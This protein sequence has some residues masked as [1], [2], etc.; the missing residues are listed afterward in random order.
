MNKTL[1][2][3]PL[4]STNVR[5]KETLTTV[6]K[7]LIDLAYQKKP[8]LSA[9]FVT[10]YFFR[11][12]MMRE[13]PHFKKWSDKADTYF[14]PVENTE[15]F[16][17]SYSWGEGPVVILM[18]GWAGRGLQL[19]SFIEPLVA[20]G[21]KVVT[22]DAPAHGDSTG[23]TTNFFEFYLS[24]KSVINYH[25]NVE[26]IIAHS[27]GCAAALANADFFSFIPKLALIAPQYDI[28][29]E[30]N[31]WSEK[32]LLSKKNF[33]KTH[34]FLEDKY[35]LD[36]ENLNPKKMASDLDAEVLLVHD[37]DDLPCP[38][39]NSVQLAKKLKQ[40]QLHLTEGLGHYRIVR[41]PKVIAKVIDFIDPKILN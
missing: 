34:R 4:K 26:S 21:Y 32:T 1:L 41:S 33:N 28:N 31:S 3:Q 37:R 39:S 12:Q 10:N 6:S 22:F 36:L 11:P 17:K 13:K 7:R 8:H 25:Q 27:M 24:L 40:G 15:H 19:Y 5:T 29:L 2:W 14:I 30:L 38:H 16:V 23:I 9:R 18:H 35:G 20:R